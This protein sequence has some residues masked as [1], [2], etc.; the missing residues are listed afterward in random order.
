M[1]EFINEEYKII[2][3]EYWAAIG[4]ISKFQ[5]KNIEKKS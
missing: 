3:E 2:T 4:G 1:A 5:S